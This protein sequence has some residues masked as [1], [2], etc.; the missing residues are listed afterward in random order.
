MLFTF[1]FDSIQISVYANSYEQ[2]KKEAEKMSRIV[3]V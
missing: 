1:I 2:A 3:K